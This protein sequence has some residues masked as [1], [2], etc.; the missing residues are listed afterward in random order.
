M[1]Q[2]M[3]LAALGV[4]GIEELAKKPLV[5]A[6]EQDVQ[7]GKTFREHEHEFYVEIDDFE[8]LKNAASVDLQEQW[9][10]R[11][12][13]TE[14]NAAKGALRIRQIYQGDL[15]LGP[16]QKPQGE[17]QYVLTTK[18]NQGIG[19]RLEVPVP[20]TEDAFNLFAML[21]DSGMIKHRYHFPVDDLVF[22]VDMF[23][24]P[25]G[26]YYPVAK[27]DL[28]VKNMSGEIPE[29]PIKVKSC[30]KGDT[31]D[32]A[33]RDQITAWFDQYFITKNKFD[34]KAVAA[35]ENLEDLNI[36][37]ENAFNLI[38][39]G[40]LGALIGG[41]HLFGKWQ[42]HK[43]EKAR[44]ASEKVKPIQ[45]Q[46][47]SRWGSARAMI[48][49]IQE[50]YAN[51]K[52]VWD[53]GTEN[54]AGTIKSNEVAIWDAV[55]INGQ[56][57]NDKMSA[58]VGTVKSLGDWVEAMFDSLQKNCDEMDSIVKALIK[59]KPDR[60]AFN[61]AMDAV[62]KLPDPFMSNL[63]L[64][65]KLSGSYGRITASWSRDKAPWYA[66]DYNVT[67]EKTQLP[68]MAGGVIR[69]MQPH[70]IV[71]T[72][73]VMIDM[74]RFLFDQKDK[75]NY[76]LYANVNEVISGPR[77]DLIEKLEEYYEK[78]FGKKPQSGTLYERIGYRFEEH[79]DVV[80]QVQD[81]FLRSMRKALLGFD[82]WIQACLKTQKS[83]N[84]GD[85]EY[86]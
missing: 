67:Q 68:K 14:G 32:K 80:S 75:R 26:G 27:I 76:S 20:T 30:I 59:T 43:K 73:E 69:V 84:N 79:D 44:V 72:G 7:D 10:I 64:F 45:E 57:P 1:K 3:K 17:A 53:Q 65:K 62:K 9:N 60:E 31:Q 19:K 42:N 74:I 36:A 52:W 2:V 37:Q 55:S 4:V 48:E 15:D 58:W 50:T 86:R 16:N 24:N 82:M 23:L 21:S 38:V 29:L 47:A 6:M 46:L 51:E 28:E 22:E 61:S 25:E 41:L 18:V 8:Q 39:L 71:K 5:V 83:N 81:A 33:E 11:I 66:P 13:K 77:E 40:G 12:D 34:S 85:H 35:L 54:W 63:E 78:A 56:L 70:Q 49:R